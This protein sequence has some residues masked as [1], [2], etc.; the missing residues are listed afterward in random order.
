MSAATNRSMTRDAMI[1]RSP[2]S[3]KISCRHCL[4]VL[5]CAYVTSI[6]LA[7]CDPGA[8]RLGFPGRGA[9][10]ADQFV[11]PRSSGSAIP[12]DSSSVRRLCEEQRRYVHTVIRIFQ[13]ESD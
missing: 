11:R 10:G 3:T 13:P 7:C 8:G 2:L 6:F 12:A 4:V 5:V 9:L 1:V